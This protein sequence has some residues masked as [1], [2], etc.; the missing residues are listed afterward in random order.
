MKNLFIVII[1]CMN[2]LN[3]YS[4]KDS[5]SNKFKKEIDVNYNWSQIGRNLSINY[6]QY[7]GRHALIIGVKQHYN[8]G[9]ITDNQN[10]VYKN[11]GYATNFSESIGLNIGY[12]F[13]LLKHHE[14]L[15]P[16]LFFQSQISK[17]RFK[18]TYNVLITSPNG[19]YVKTDSETSESVFTTENNFGFGLKVK[20]FKNI[21]LNQTIGGGIAT[22]KRS[23][24]FYSNGRLT[25]YDFELCTSIKIGLIY[26][27]K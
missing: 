13:D 22:F 24:A 16:Y 17:I 27:F 20:L 10:Y 15:M 19:Y 14:Y 6:N 8:N 18:E 4:Q 7:F 21:F 3:Y 11:R 12:K 1:I 5:I 9:V 2:A 26:Q 23:E 25:K